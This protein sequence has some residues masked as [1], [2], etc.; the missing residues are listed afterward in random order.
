MGS[1]KTRVFREF[2]EQQVQTTVS[3]KELQRQE[4]VSHAG[5]KEMYQMV[6]LKKHNEQAVH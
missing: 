6:I 2:L 3:T 5:P 1:Q 4:S